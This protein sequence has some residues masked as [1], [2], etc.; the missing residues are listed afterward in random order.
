LDNGWVSSEVLNI[1]NLWGNISKILLYNQT[2]D[3]LSQAQ[4]QLLRWNSPANSS[5]VNHENLVS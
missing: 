1:S 5:L 3:M 2:R 4:L